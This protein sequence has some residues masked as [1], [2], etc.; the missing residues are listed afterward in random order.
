MTRAA[1]VVHYCSGNR[2]VLLLAAVDRV[3]AHP[4]H[5]PQ[6]KDRPIVARAD[7]VGRTVQFVR[8]AVF[9]HGL[10]IDELAQVGNVACSRKQTARCC[11][12]GNSSA[13]IGR[14]ER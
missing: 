3:T 7:H 12:A 6:R 5:R 14:G 13:T 1:A 4:V 2:A 8:S 11:P 9:M 10:M